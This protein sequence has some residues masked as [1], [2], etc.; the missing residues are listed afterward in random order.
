MTTCTEKH[1]PNH[2]TPISMARTAGIPRFATTAMWTIFTT[3]IST[4]CM[5]ITSTNM[6]SR[7]TPQIPC[8][9]RLKPAAHTSTAQTADT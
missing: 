7:S 6:S 5:K 8:T 1:H 9:A 2:P 4:I 3:A